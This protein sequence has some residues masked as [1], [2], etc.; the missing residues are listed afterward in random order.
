MQDTIS[1][2]TLKIVIVGMLV[3]FLGLLAGGWK[4]VHR[5]KKHAKAQV[6]GHGDLLNVRNQG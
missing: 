1:Q 2:M 6:S 5:I 4:A 3:T